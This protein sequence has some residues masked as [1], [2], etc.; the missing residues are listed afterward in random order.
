[1]TKKKE[2][3]ANGRDIRNLFERTVET[4]AVR[5]RSAKTPSLLTELKPEDLLRAV[6]KIG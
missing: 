6:A 2:N 1:M 4:Q 3:F 5:I